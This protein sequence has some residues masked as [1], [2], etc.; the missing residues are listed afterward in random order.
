MKLTLGL[1]AVSLIFAHFN[2]FAQEAKPTEPKA[3]THESEASIVKVGGN[4]TADSYSAKQKTSYKFDMNILTGSARYLQTKA[5]SVETARQ[6]EGSLRYERELS[7]KWSIFIQHGAESDPFA[8]Y[9][10]RDST[11]LGG[12]YFFIKTEPETFFS[13][14]GARYQKML[15]SANGDT[16]YATLG[17]LYLEY[18]KKIN[19]SV[20]GKL[21]VEYLPN[22]KDSDA[23][24]V[25]YE[26][27]VSVMMSQIFSLK[28]AYLVKYHNKTVTATEKKE[29]TTFTTALV[30][31]F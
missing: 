11:D 15:S 31:K 4:T 25:N 13:E 3:W 30:A 28:V 14:A 9:T 29:D 10:Q 27:S 21:W 5:G 19:D 23:Y 8:G 6:W 18:T 12:K 20:S 7:E 17:R 16:T 22:F 26:P 24:L 2:A 1:V